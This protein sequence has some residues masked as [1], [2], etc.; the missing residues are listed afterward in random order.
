MKNLYGEDI[1]ITITFRKFGSHTVDVVHEARHPWPAETTVSAGNGVVM[2]RG[3]PGYTTLFMEVYPPGASFIRGEGK[4]P[5]E[6]EDAC[7]V[8]Y[9]AAL[10]CPNGTGHHWEPRHYTNGAALC[11][12]CNTFKPDVFTGEQL[13]Q[14]CR[15]CGIGTRY[16][17][18][19][20]GSWTCRDHTQLVESVLDDHWNDEEE[21]R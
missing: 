9:Q 20:D 16:H 11:R 5:A 15:A 10:N 3:K 17:R 18:D 4:T 13:G 2:R 6:C 8:K 19:P 7:W 14:F 1:G 12:H 21:D